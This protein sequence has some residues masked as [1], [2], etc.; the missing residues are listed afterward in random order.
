MNNPLG[1][2][3][4]FRGVVLVQGMH[5]HAVARGARCLGQRV[6]K[7]VVPFVGDTEPVHRAEH[8]WPVRAKQYNATAAQGHFVQPLDRIV[9]H[10]RSDG[11]RSIDV[12]RQPA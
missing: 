12:R 1:G 2:E 9:G 11:R 6:A 5:R 3:V 10:L 8:D 4:A 7:G